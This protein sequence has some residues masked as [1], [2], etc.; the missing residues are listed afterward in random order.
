MNSF[1]FHLFFC[2]NM[3]RFYL[4]DFRSLKYFILIFE[5]SMTKKEKFFFLPK[6]YL[7]K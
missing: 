2:L 4:K 3:L 1:E 6:I 7:I 5:K